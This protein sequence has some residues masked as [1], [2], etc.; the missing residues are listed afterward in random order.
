V[1]DTDQCPLGAGVPAHQKHW[2]A[3][4]SKTPSVFLVVFVKEKK[5]ATKCRVKK[6]RSV[7]KKHPPEKPV[8]KQRKLNFG[9]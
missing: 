5:V 6:K 8:V 2:I 9:G 4:T 1:S 7:K 3:A